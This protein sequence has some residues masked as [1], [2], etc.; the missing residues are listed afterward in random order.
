[1]EYNYN[2]ID[3]IYSVMHEISCEIAKEKDE[4]IYKACLTAFETRKGEK[5]VINKT[6]LFNAIEHWQNLVRC[7]ECNHW[8]DFYGS[9]EQIKM[10]EIGKY[11]VGENG[12]CC[13]G[14]RKQE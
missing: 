1:M 12:Y 9:T 5:I 6:E 2:P 14:E 8:I 11:A 13:Y 10:C 4:E 3:D 7:K